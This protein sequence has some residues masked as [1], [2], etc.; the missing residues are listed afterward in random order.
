MRSKPWLPR[1]A[2]RRHDVRDGEERR[3]QRLD[4]LLLIRNT[5]RALQ[6]QPREVIGQVEY[7]DAAIAIE[8]VIVNEEDLHAPACGLSA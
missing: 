6:T 5:D 8:V 7:V 1:A 2:A 4:R 3:T